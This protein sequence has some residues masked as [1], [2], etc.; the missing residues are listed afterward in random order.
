[1]RAA[2]LVALAVVIGAGCGGGDAPICTTRADPLQC[3]PDTMRM[4]Q[5]SVTLG[6]GRDS[7]EAM[8]DVLPLEFGTQN[9]YDVVANVRM[10][11]F[12]PGNL[13]SIVDPG[14]P[15]TRIRA[16]FADTNVPLSAA[17]TCPF[18]T[19]YQ[20]AAA[21]DHD[22]EFPSGVPIIFDLCWRSDRLI[23]KRIRIELELMDD[24]GGYTTDT[25][26]VTLAAPLGNYPME[27]N[28]PGCPQP[29]DP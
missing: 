6:T 18:R 12:D 3:W 9:G 17:S 28:T 13:Q 8:P 5:G 16:F 14:N 1:M 22:Y 10:T 23:G 11:G 25:R 7:F 20:R 27:E 26:T 15:R 4:P 19:A 29:A 24:C 21:G 2:A